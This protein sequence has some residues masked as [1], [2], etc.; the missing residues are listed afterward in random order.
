M[1]VF[2]CSVYL[3]W[4]I[5]CI[6]NIVL[7]YK[8][9]LRKPDNRRVAIRRRYKRALTYCTCLPAQCDSMDQNARSRVH[10]EPKS[11]VHRPR[12]KVHGSPRARYSTL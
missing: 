2:V 4:E 6:L 7:L 10:S 3:L 8:N 12:S 9:V 5:Y 1:G 11:K